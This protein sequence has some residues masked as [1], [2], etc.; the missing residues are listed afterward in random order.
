M[1]ESVTET[2]PAVFLAVGSSSVKAVSRSSSG[3]TGAKATSAAVM[4]WML[5]AA[6]VNTSNIQ[7]SS[8]RSPGPLIVQ[9]LRKSEIKK[10]NEDHKL[11]AVDTPKRHTKVQT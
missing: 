3:P 8:T 4:L 5:Y 6:R 11:C 10:K 9:D 2:E 7:P 1:R